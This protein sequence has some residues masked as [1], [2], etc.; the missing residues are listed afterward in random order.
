MSSSS[1]LSTFG[2]NHEELVSGFYDCELEGVKSDE[3]EQEDTND[4]LF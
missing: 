4:G 3:K 2:H 1:R